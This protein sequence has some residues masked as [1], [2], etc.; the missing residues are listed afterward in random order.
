MLPTLGV[1]AEVKTNV[2]EGEPTTISN[3]VG[4]IADRYA[5][6]ICARLSKITANYI[7][8]GDFTNYYHHVANSRFIDT[9]NTG[10][11]LKLD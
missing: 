1:T 5:G 2:G 4:I 8:P 3:T 6:G 9:R 7:A 11:I 10:I